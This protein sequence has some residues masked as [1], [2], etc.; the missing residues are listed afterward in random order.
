MV[1]YFDRLDLGFSFF[2]FPFIVRIN[3]SSFFL[4]LG[5]ILPHLRLIS[6][7]V[8]LG[9]CECELMQKLPFFD[10]FQNGY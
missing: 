7:S 6:S 9:D 3:P 8:S 10:E 4:N 2:Y 1:R 5:L